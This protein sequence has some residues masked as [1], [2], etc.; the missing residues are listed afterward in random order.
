[1][2]ITEMRE[3]I[4]EIEEFESIVDEV[5]T[6]KKNI[7]YSETISIEGSWTSKKENKEKRAEILIRGVD[8]IKLIKPFI[9]EYE[10]YLLNLYNS[11]IERLQEAGIEIE[12]KYN[13]KKQIKE[14][15][16]EEE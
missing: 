13:K 12:S 3:K 5:L 8:E 11:K 10:K 6:F 16:V 7:K 14:G 9:K 2:T 4:E 15:E 1:M